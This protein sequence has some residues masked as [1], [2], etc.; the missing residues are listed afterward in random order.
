M[1]RILSVLLIALLAT[2]AV[3]ADWAFSGNFDIGYTFGFDGDTTLTTIDGDNSAPEAGFLYLKGGND[4]ISFDVRGELDAMSITDGN[5]AFGLVRGG[6]IGMTATLNAT[7]LLNLAF[8]LELPVDVNFYLGNQSPESDADYAYAD[9]SGIDDEI[10]LG[11]SR[12]MYPAGVSVGYGSLITGYAYAALDILNTTGNAGGLFEIRTNPIAGVRANIGYVA[13]AAETAQDFQVSALVD[14]GELFG[15][16]FGLDVSASYVANI[17]HAE[18]NSHFM[19]AVT[20]SYAGFG[21]YA[22][23]EYY[24]DTESAA[25]GSD[26][27]YDKVSNVYLGVSYDL[28]TAVPVSLGADLTL[29]NVQDEDAFS[30]GG[31]VSVGLAILDLN[32]YAELG[33]EDF[34]DG[35]TGY[36]TVGTYIYF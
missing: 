24:N 16:G 22:E 20:G 10:S 36:V 14:F 1:K 12:N 13:S 2:T 3:F 6:G 34:S 26:G 8:G 9:P 29:N 33:V 27:Y 35:D 7:N 28:A 21:A 19:A 30:V 32:L 4:Y 15:L 31:D 17:D 5:N 18:D 23:Y 25:P 11:A